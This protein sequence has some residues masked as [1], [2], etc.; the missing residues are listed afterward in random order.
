VVLLPFTPWALLAYALGAVQ[1]ATRSR[2]VGNFSWASALLYPV[3]LLFFFVVFT[4][5][6]LRSG[7]QVS[8]KGR[9]IH[10]D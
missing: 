8:W 10:A 4:R 1:V 3:P 5:S 6:A 7:K 9:S 2:Q